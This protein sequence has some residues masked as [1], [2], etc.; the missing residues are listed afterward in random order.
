MFIPVGLDTA[1]LGCWEC[2]LF[3][4]KICFSYVCKGVHPPVMSTPASGNPAIQ[5]PTMSYMAGPE[6]V[7]SGKH[8][9]IYIY[10]SRIMG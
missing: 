10:F 3:D 4:V 6:I 2:L 8:N 5:A 9:G 7:Y 1:D